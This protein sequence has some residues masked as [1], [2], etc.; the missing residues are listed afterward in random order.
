M[1]PG[2]VGFKLPFLLADLAVAG[3]LAY[4][5]RSSGGRSF[6]L[7][8]YVWNPLVIVEFAS[9]GHNDALAIAAVV[10]TL[11][12]IRRHPALSTLSLTAGAL[13]KAFPAVLL[14]RSR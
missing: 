5:I 2:P 7:A 10:A 14:P 9:S 11:L 12:I 3:M 6:Q 1:L 4:W 13:A 8:I